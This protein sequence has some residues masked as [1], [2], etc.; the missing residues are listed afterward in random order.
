[1]KPW[2]HFCEMPWSRFDVKCLKKVSQSGFQTFNINAV[3]RRGGSTLHWLQW[4]VGSWVQKLT[5]FKGI[6]MR[7]STPFRGTLIRK[8]SPFWMKRGPLLC[9]LNEFGHEGHVKNNSLQEKYAHDLADVFTAFQTPF[10]WQN[11]TKLDIWY[12]ISSKYYPWVRVPVLLSSGQKS[13]PFPWF[14]AHPK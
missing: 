9:M 3:Y 6:W 4:Y 2:S 1:M 7:K 5:H 14:D 11:G 8:S 10:Y 13:T 12:P